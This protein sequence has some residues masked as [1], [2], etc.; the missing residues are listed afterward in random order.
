MPLK[1][2][3]NILEWVLTWALSKELRVG[4]ASEIQIS[5]NLQCRLYH[6]VKCVYLRT[7]S[8][9]SFLFDRRLN[10]QTL[11][12]CLRFWRLLNSSTQI[13]VKKS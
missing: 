3:H 9:G 11:I 4:L 8:S 5:Q 13:F 10:T 1:L 12:V 7:V 2:F 6:N